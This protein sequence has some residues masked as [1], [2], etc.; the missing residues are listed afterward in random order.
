MAW[1]ALASFA[2]GSGAQQIAN[3]MNNHLSYPGIEPDESAMTDRAGL[4]NAVSEFNKSG[5]DIASGLVN[6]RISD[7]SI[8][9]AV[10]EAMQGL[11]GGTYTVDT[12]AQ[13]IQDA[14]DTLK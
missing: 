13:H 14:Q 10:Q 12:A 6:Q 4:K 2:A 1:K 5:D 11:V 8:E 7:P 9:T 3:D